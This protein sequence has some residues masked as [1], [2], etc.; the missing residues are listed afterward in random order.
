MLDFVFTQLGVDEGRVNHPVVMTETLCN[1]H[2]P[3]SR[4]PLLSSHLFAS[5]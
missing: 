1:P 3:R 5:L 4:T 2:Y